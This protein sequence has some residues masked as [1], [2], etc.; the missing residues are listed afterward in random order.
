MTS[1]RDDILGAIRGRQ[2][3]RDHTRARN[4]VKAWLG[5]H[6]RNPVPARADLPAPEKVDL[7]VSFASEA[8]ATVTRVAKPEDVPATVADYLRDQNL[9]L[10]VRQAGD[11]S[12]D[13]IPW[14]LAPMLERKPGKAIPSDE[15]SLTG[16]F[17]AVAETG[18]LVLTSGPAHP[19]T[20]NFLP[21]THVVVLRASQVVGGMEDMWDRLRRERAAGDGFAMPRTVNFVTGPSRSA[22]IEQTLQLGAHGPRRLHIVVID[23]LE[24]EG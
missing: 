15:V 14:D 22:D 10:S 19:T 24:E 13:S 2:R 17:A 6:A 21:E 18:T 7:F 11:P 5:A 3:G 16:A 1:A 20:L 4:M 23:D 9:P 12:L 8:D